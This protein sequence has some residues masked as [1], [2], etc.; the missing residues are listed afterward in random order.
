MSKNKTI[1]ITWFV[2]V[3]SLILVTLKI[4]GCITWSWWWVLSPLWIIEGI[5]LIMLV[6]LLIRDEE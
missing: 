1:N 5:A 4:T 3:K 2:I 6:G